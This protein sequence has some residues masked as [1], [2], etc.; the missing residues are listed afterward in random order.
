MAR[1]WLGSNG[2]FFLATLV[3]GQRLPLLLVPLFYLVL[4]IATSKN[5]Q[6][7]PLKLVIVAM[8]SLL[9]VMLIPLFGKEG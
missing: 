8:L 6:K 4:F 3:S 7:L 5:K 2:F 1:R 9:A